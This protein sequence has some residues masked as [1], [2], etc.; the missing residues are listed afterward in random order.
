MK[1]FFAVLFLATAAFPSFAQPTRVETF[2]IAADEAQNAYAVKRLLLNHYAAPIVRVLHAAYAADGRLVQD[3]PRGAAPLEV[4]LGAERKQPFALVKIPVSNTA[5]EG[6]L[7][8]VTLEVKE[9]Q[10][11]ATPFPSAALKTTAGSSVL[12]AGSWHKL[13]V[14]DRGV[15]KIDYAFL[16]STL[17]ISAPISSTAI[18]LYGNGG[19][20][21][22]EAV[23]AS[24]ADD[25]SEVALQVLDGGDGSFDAGDYLLFYAPGHTTWRWDSAKRAFVHAK[26]IYEDKSYYLL[27]VGGSGKRISTQAGTPTPNVT[28]TSF[29]DYTALNDDKI[30]IG[31]FG[32]RWWGDEMGSGPG[33][34]PTRSYSFNLGGVVDSMRSRV[35]LAIGNTSTPDALTVSL[36]GQQVHAHNFSTGSAGVDQPYGSSLWENARPWSSP[37]ATFDFSFQ[38]SGSASRGFVDF[39]EL[40]WRRPLQY[41]GGVLNFRDVRSAGQGRV[42][43][44]QIAGANGAMQVW[45]VTDASSPERMTGSL[46]GSTYSFSREAETVREFVAADGSSA[47]PSY[48][49]QVSN[50]NLHGEGQTD[51]IIVTHPTFKS[52]ADRLAEH[53]R[54]KSG[55]RVLVATVDKIYNEF[56]SGSQDITAIRDFVR[57][58]Y[59]RAGADTT[60]M[61]RYLLMFGDASYDYKDRVANNTN[62]VPTYEAEQSE[63]LIA[64][65]TGDDFFAML[66]GNEDINSGAVFN[67]LDVGVGRIP[68][69]TA[70][71]AAAAA[72][73]IIRY[74]S[75]ASFGPWRLS[76]T[77]V[78][79]NEDN[80]GNHMMDA[81]A[82]AAD[83]NRASHHYNETKVYLDNIPFVS[84]PGGIRAPDA[85]KLINDGVFRGT[86]LINYS[87]HGSPSTLA[88]ERVIT[89]EDFNAWRNG[90][91]MPIMVTATCDFG[92]FDQPT[93]VSAGEKLVLKGDGGAI[94]MLTTVHAV[95]ASQSRELNGNFLEDLFG[96]TPGK[97]LPAFGDALR[98][99]KNQ[100]YS[101]VMNPGSLLNFRKFTLLGD[102]ALVPAFPKEKINTDSVVELSTGQRQDTFKALGGYTIHG[103]VRDEET[104]A[105]LNDFNGR[106]YV[107]IYDKARVTSFRTKVYNE[108]R[109]FRVRSNVVY[110]GIT[111]ATGGRFSCSFIAPKDLNYEYGGS[112]ISYYAENGEMDAVGTDTTFKAGG[113]SDNPVV[114]NNPPSVRPYMND[115]L[116]RNGGL[117]GSN[118]LLYVVLEDETGINVSGNAV[119]HDLTAVLDGAVQKPYILNDYYQTQPNTYRRGYVRFPITDLADGRHSLRVKAWDANNNS[120]E[121]TVNFEV[122]NGAI[123]RVQN[124]ACYPNPFRTTTRFVWEHNQPEEAVRAEIQ[125]FSTAGVL[126]RRI[127][128][129]WTPTGSRSAEVSW[130]GTSDGGAALPAGVYLYRLVFTGASGLQATAYEKAVLLR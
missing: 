110:K 66:D 92:Q 21:L 38:G 58:F 93:F 81:E 54:Q 75:P 11:A 18:R 17:K 77:Y 127:S 113:F 99:G 29:D 94:A 123:T 112:R 48:I 2:T 46:F 53:H 87:G 84:T 50:Q 44:Y 106:V 51:Y 71:E 103:S 42:A 79:D 98:M 124:L 16:T 7:R 10:S 86:F 129:G 56:S 24:R 52:A 23:N 116:F 40:N 60:Q 22:P 8:E 33:K 72:D 128:E 82:N 76:T 89:A 74:H 115:S 107:A 59:A 114:E 47:V 28:V 80:A 125:I 3:T 85:N 122:A 91:K 45:D 14:P 90:N 61:P 68:V 43:A 130:D 117:T 97:P 4:I 9:A 95:Y 78:G 70:D 25:L 121:G 102:P 35:A 105:V 96:R 5:F 30:N 69:K 31:S 32:R 73:K 26:N 55:L 12:S 108:E 88:H 101:A 111:T 20:M 39:I 36:N 15:Y 65:F 104:G 34:E 41:A 27:T 1:H 13:A 126:V 67:T 63:A 64:T 83:V 118:T 62:Y 109:T 6:S 49:G 100:T 119:G 57:M 120:G 37:T 19:Q